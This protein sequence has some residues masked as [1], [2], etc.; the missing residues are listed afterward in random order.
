MDTEKQS[1]DQTEHK[2]LPMDDK[3]IHPTHFQIPEVELK[4]RNYDSGNEWVD[5]GNGRL[6]LVP[7]KKK[8][9]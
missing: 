3:T 9:N 1:R 5:L 6:K 7:K 2:T 4:D 8:N